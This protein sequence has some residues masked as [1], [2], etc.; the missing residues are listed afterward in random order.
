MRSLFLLKF[1]TLSSLLLNG[2]TALG[3][4]RSGHSD[5]RGQT[6]TP[7]DPDC[8]E[9]G[10]E[11]DLERFPTKPGKELYHGSRIKPRLIEKDG[12]LRVQGKPEPNGAPMTYE[13][14]VWTS[15]HHILAGKFK[16]EFISL[17]G[18]LEIAGKMLKIYYPVYRWRYIYVIDTA[19]IEDEFQFVKTLYKND[20]KI[21]P[22]GEGEDEW[23]TRKDIPWSAIIGWYKVGTKDNRMWWYDNPTRYGP[24]NSQVHWTHMSWLRP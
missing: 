11:S 8:T 22:F 13:Q 10:R 19:G 18:S 20:G 6:P 24:K 14:H 15:R 4:P 7:G 17:E 23:I 3:P 5:V 16:T 12:G 2:A 1:L 21:H 9:D